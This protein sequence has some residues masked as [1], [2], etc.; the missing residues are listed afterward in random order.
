MHA[1]LRRRR[2][3]SPSPENLEGRSLLSVGT[4]GAAFLV[5]TTQGHGQGARALEI[6]VRSLGGTIEAS[7][8]GAPSVVRVGSGVDAAWA[9]RRLGMTWG[10]RYVEPDQTVQRDAAAPNDPKFASQWGLDNPGGVDVR[11]LAAWDVTAGVPGVIVAV[12][13]SGV[14]VTHPDLAGR[15]WA[16]PKEVARN[17]VDDDRNGK[18]DDTQGWNFVDNTNN[19]RD[20]DG[21]GTH[22]AGIIAA[23]ANNATGGSGVAPGVRIMP[24]KFLNW[25]GSGQISD[26][27]AAIYYAVDNG[28]RV[29]NAS[30]AG[31]D[32]SQSLRDAIQYARGRNV[33]FVAAAGNDAANLDARATYPASFRLSNMLVVAAVDRAG[34]LS[35]FSNWGARGVDV[36]APGTDIVSTVPSGRYATYSGTSMAT[37]F[38][39][40]VAALVLSVTPTMTSDQVVARIRSTAAPVPSLAG[41]VASGGVVD[42]FAAVTGTTSP[43]VPGSSAPSSPS[44]RLADLRPSLLGSDAYFTLHGRSWSGF[45]DGLYRDYFGRA[46]GANDIQY[47]GNQMYLGM[48]RDEVARALQG[49]VE[50]RRT[51]VALWFVNDLGR[52]AAMLD[53]LKANPGIIALADL[54]AAGVPAE[55]VRAGIFASDEFRARSGGTDALYL[56]NLYVNLLGRNM[57]QAEWNVWYPRLTA[58]PDRAGVAMEVLTY[59]ETRLTTL[60]RWYRDD[61]GVPYTLDQL[62]ANAAIATLAKQVVG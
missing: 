51:E 36:A 39:S 59:D 60:A 41:R 14:D 56:A 40:G 43:G 61:M 53:A 34:S 48:G 6:V 13:D 44:L 24:L 62:K 4:G 25:A 28:A 55:N 58:H 10:V 9:Q 11:A 30:W 49:A 47:W 54:I 32:Y 42:A 50:A 3:Y 16:N 18:V 33:V 20:D 27:V 7:E 29:I 12:I 26:A 38:V 5:G 46:A 2:R 37:P 52:P 31:P 15:I 57:T 23:A 35:S 22:V 21:H 45:I 1:T 17:R 8:P 19:V